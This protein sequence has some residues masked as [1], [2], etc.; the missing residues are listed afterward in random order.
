MGYKH[1]PAV[2]GQELFLPRKRTLQK[3]NGR[4]EFGEPTSSALGRGVDYHPCTIGIGRARVRVEDNEDVL[5][6]KS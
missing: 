2:V 1:V 6:R 5:S 4:N 3:V